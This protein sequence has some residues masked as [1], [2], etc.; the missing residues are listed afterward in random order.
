MNKDLN[1]RRLIAVS[2]LALLPIARSGTVPTPTESYPPP[3]QQVFQDLFAAVQGQAIYGDQKTFPD[4]LPQADP[5][6]ILA[7]YH[8]LHPTS[9]EALKRF[10]DGRFALPDVAAP[11][12]A[13][14]GQAP[15]VIHIDTLWDQ[16]T[17]NTPAAPRFSSLLPLPAP[18]VVPGGRFREIYYWD[19]YFT[20]LGLDECGRHD[21][22]LDMVRD[23]AFLIDTYG[24]VPNGT[25]S[26]YL[27]RSQPPFFFEMVG[28]LGQDDRPR[29][30]AKYLPQ[31]MR[32]Y[33][34]WMQGSA[35][36]R[37]G[38]AHRR[39][40]ALPDGSILNRYWDDRDTPRDESYLQDSE[41]ARSSARPP[42]QVFREIRAAAESGWDFSSRW[43][44]D[45][46]S[47]ATIDTT[48]ILPVD[49]NSLLYGLEDSIRM[50][51]QFHGDQVCAREFAHRAAARLGAIDR[52]LWD[53]RLGA[54]LDY[55]WT[56]RL[57]IGRLS[58]ATLYPLFVG[59]ASER[60]ASAVAR[61][62]TRDLLKSAGLVTTPIATGEQWD[63]PNGWAPI[64]WIAIAGLRR[65]GK[66]SLAQSIAC[67]WT[68]NVV[69]VYRQTGKLVEKY[70]VMTIG[71]SGGGGEYP[72]QDGFGWTNGVTRKLLALYPACGEP[73]VTDMGSASPGATGLPSPASREPKIPALADRVPLA[74][75]HSDN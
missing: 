67:R 40:V 74:H 36:L 46:R 75:T 27:S 71:R 6:E 51:C 62:A 17:R 45:A 41:L 26:Y 60:Q 23:F 21:L 18:Y 14:P 72:L 42:A 22:V 30:F 47:R 3:P 9:L 1:S 33:A 13:E 8:A 39:V 28:L 19:S 29:A 52:Y 43:F 2:V 37:P 70:D 35:G 69:A 57:R 25:R 5:D 55:R 63:A 56:Q 7:Q 24:H 64:Q 58:A 11:A 10:T 44:A 53:P 32:E 34:F 49:L 31:L 12:D 38:S 4:A 15:I 48:E 59:L 68:R 61:I 54:Y 65:Y 73:A 16:L 66:Q 20:M 50:G